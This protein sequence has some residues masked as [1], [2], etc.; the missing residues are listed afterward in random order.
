MK[1]LLASLL[2]ASSLCLAGCSAS[3]SSSSVKGNLT[4]S[5]YEA[6]VYSATEAKARIS[7]LNFEGIDL[8]EAVYAT[9]GSEDNADLFLVFFFSS[10][11]VATTFFE[12]NNYENM[13]MMHRYAESNLGKNLTVKVGTKNNTAYCGSETALSVAF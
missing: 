5:G 2:L 13:A 1:K 6:T 9:K 10:I 7:G 11:D 12:R 3:E 8:T 4:R